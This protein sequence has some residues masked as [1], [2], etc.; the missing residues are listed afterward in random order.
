MASLTMF[1]WGYDGWG[2]S[3]R[4]LKEAVDAVEQERGFDPP[5]FVDL[6]ISR[7]VRAEG[8]RENAFE[9]AVG[10]GRYQW[11]P[12]LGN[13]RLT[14]RT[15]PRIQIDLSQFQ[16]MRRCRHMSMQCTTSRTFGRQAKWV[17]EA[18][19][20]ATQVGGFSKMSSSKRALVSGRRV[21]IL[22]NRKGP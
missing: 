13:K 22:E 5:L 15:G 17:A 14:R 16:M 20:R 19:F 9:K 7:S 10:R 12:S 18:Y 6:R 8:F 21:P 11:M 1:T 2:S 4:Q 3:T